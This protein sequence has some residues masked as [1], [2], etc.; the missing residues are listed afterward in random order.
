MET[1]ML[2]EYCQAVLDLC[3]T[4]FEVKKGGN[5]HDCYNRRDLNG[6]EQ[7][8]Q[9]ATAPVPEDPLPVSNLSSVKF[10]QSHCSEAA[11]LC[12]KALDLPSQVGE[13][14]DSERR[15][16]ALYGRL[17]KF[18]VLKSRHIEARSVWTRSQTNR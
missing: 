1:H 11:Q 5:D 10:E 8:Y 2:L 3:G 18:Y 16:A 9:E 14:P 4:T 15:R 17:I 7:A 13:N 6:A 12:N